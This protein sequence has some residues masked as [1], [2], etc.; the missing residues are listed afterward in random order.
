MSWKTSSS[1]RATIEARVRSPLIDIIRMFKLTQR[2]WAT[3]VFAL[4][5]EVDP[6]LVQ[7]YRYLARA[8]SLGR[9]VVP[10]ARA[11]EMYQPEL[12]GRTRASRFE[13]R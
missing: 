9:F 8:S 7:G 13:V 4:M 6:N 2:Q 3:L 11:E 12:F 5:P 10:P 1:I